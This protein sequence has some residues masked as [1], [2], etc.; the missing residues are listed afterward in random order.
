MARDK[1]PGV[2][3]LPMEVYKV[4]QGILLPEL[5][6]VFEFSLDA[7]SL[8]PSM[9]EALIVVIP[10][11]GKDPKY[12]DS[13]RPIL[14]LTVDVKLLTKVLATR[15]SRLILTIVHP[16]QTGFM[17]GKSTAI[18]IRRLYTSLQIPGEDSGDRAV[19]TL[20]AAKAFDSI[21]WKYLWTVL[22]C[23]GFGTQFIRW[24]QVLY[25][26]PR[27]RIRANGG[28]SDYI[29]LQRDYATRYPEAIP[30]RHTS[31]KLIA[32]ELMGMFSQVGIPKEILTDQGTPFMSK[33]MKELCRLLNVK[34]LHTSVYHPQT[35]GLVERFN[36]TLKTML[37]RAVS[38]DG[39][40]WDLLL[41]YVLFG[42]REVPQAST[43]FSP[44]KLLYG[45]HPRG[46]LDGT[47]EAWEQQPTPHKSVIE[48][49]EK[50][51]ERIGTVLP[52]VRD[53]M[54][55][56]Q[57]AQ[58]QVY[59]RATQVRTF[60][61]GDRVL[62]LVPTVDS[63][64]LARWQGPYEVMEKV[65]PVNYKVYQPGRQKPTLC[66]DCGEGSGSTSDPAES[67]LCVRHDIV[68][69]PQVKV[70]L[71]P[72]RM[73]E[74]RR[75]A[76]SKEVKSMLRLGV[77]EESRKQST[78]DISTDN[79]PDDCTRNL[80][81]PLVSL[82]FEVDDCGITR[83][84]FEE[85]ANIQDI[86]SSNHSNNASFDSFKQVR[87]S[88]SSQTVTQNKSHRRSAKHPTAHVEEKPF[89]CS[90]CGKSF[91][92]KSHLVIHERTH[93]GEKPFS[94]SECGKCF[95]RQSHLVIHQRIHIGEKPFSCS[96]CGKCFNQKSTLVRHQ[97]TH[98]EE[99]PFSCSDCG[100]CFKQKSSLFSHKKTH[101]EKPFSCSECS[102]R[103]TRKSYLVVHQRTHTEERPFS[104]SECGKCFTQKS[105][106]VIHQRIHT[107]E[108]PFSC[109]ECGKCFK[110]KS[111]LVIHQR[112]HTGEK[113]FSCSECG[114]CFKQK[115]YL[116]I[117][118]RIHTGEKPFSCSECGKCFSNNP[119]LVVHHRTHTGEKPYSC[120]ECGKCFKHKSNLDKHQKVHTGE[121]PFSCSECG[122]C[123]NQKSA[124]V[125]H[126]KT[127]REERPFSCS[128]CGKCFKQKSSLFSH[129]KTH[130]EEK[131]FSCSECSKR[132]TRKSYLVVHQRNHTEERPFSCSECGKCFTQ[133]SYLVIHQRI[134]TGEKPFSCS[135]CGKCFKQKSYLV[136]HQRI[137]TGEK[138]FSCS[139]CGK[140]F[141]QK[142]YLF[143]H[144]ET[145]REEKPFSCSECS[146]RFTRKSYLVVHQRNHTEERPFSCSECGKC[147]KQKST[148]FSHKKTHR[149]ER[150]F[151]CSEWY[152]S[153]PIPVTTLDALL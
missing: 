8:P 116:F 85:H 66:L 45:R 64:F 140:C 15:L 7:G 120:S 5:L 137:H 39:K 153:P 128:D 78:E 24:V 99:R 12:P 35:D 10:K 72:Y 123:F 101:K 77:I 104:C 151:S 25:S 69:E 30:L 94:C 65:G 84:T 56:A 130:R 11:P 108:K 126:Q 111:Y 74:A 124:L 32:K 76:I 106:L 79:R 129:K 19:L 86:S 33:V 93:T 68:T 145:H 34:H 146:K 149:E 87:C 40:D 139:E 117:H 122:K 75:Q 110:Q 115:S 16:D 60:N 59:N 147:F 150:P 13:Y 54:E 80:E 58:S 44:F 14:L 109:S 112:I 29:N 20:D 71:K 61:L 63:K 52:I 132:F 50:M 2:D 23:M 91:N 38:K 62:L 114:K 51:Q 37:K 43:G 143:I 49:I 136:I 102:K 131:P 47:K 141:K 28:I 46:L 127:H 148:L 96:E 18:N 48:H 57:L 138:P 22:N 17:P 97:K 142:S 42:V 27:A 81:K 113:P 70:R 88:D 121:K 95:H 21:E 92:H 89:S 144:Q 83:D 36:K 135:E 53:H 133:K 31:A 119:E 82:D 152:C 107:G 98:R 73:P 3:G 9:Q 90:E 4:F 100:K 1:A 105:Y 67:L 103:F 41:P 125:T 134:H 26:T 118:Q 6:K 55:A